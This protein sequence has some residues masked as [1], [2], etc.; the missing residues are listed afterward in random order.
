[1]GSGDPEVLSWG[2]ELKG[3]EISPVGRDEKRGEELSG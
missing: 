1:M 3:R 2:K